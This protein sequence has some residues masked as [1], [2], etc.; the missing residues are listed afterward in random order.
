MTIYSSIRQNNVRPQTFAWLKLVLEKLDNKDV[1]GYL[2]L[3]APEV[4]IGF[5]NDD[6]YRFKGQEEA[7][8]GLGQ[9]W[10][11]F[12]S[13]E[14]EELNLYCSSPTT[15]RSSTLSSSSA[16]EVGAEG[17]DEEKSTGEER[18]EDGGDRHLVHE[19]LNH[20]V[21]L[22]GRKVTLKAVAFIDRDEQGRI[23][24]LRI[25]SDQSPLFQ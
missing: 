5:N 15:T 1:E 24:H 9:F 6:P 14:H 11:S 23:E 7:R 25:Y 2:A 4:M 22:D 21:T 18:T 10:Q 8:K 16:S 3:C 13:I 19:A 12:Q 17:G 20:Y